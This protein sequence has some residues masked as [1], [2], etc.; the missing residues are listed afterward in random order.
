MMNTRSL[1]KR[2]SPRK[3]SSE[4]RTLSTLVAS[5]SAVR[6]T[7]LLFLLLAVAVKP[8]F[9]QIAADGS[10]ANDTTAACTTITTLPFNAASSNEPLLAFVALV[11]GMDRDPSQGEEPVMRLFSVVRAPRPIERERRQ[12]SVGW[13][14]GRTY[15]L[16]IA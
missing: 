7:L 4:R 6:N 9:A 10:V 16:H 14:R 13:G 3:G 8:A 2:W 11:F 12:G 5:V 15:V 1:R